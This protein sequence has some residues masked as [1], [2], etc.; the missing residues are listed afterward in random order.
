MIINKIDT[1]WMHIHQVTQNSHCIVRYATMSLWR[2]TLENTNW[3]Q[4]PINF[5]RVNPS[6]LTIWSI[7]FKT[8]RLGFYSSLCIFSLYY[9]YPSSL[10]TPS[11]IVVHQNYSFFIN[12]LFVKLIYSLINWQSID[13]WINSLSNLLSVK[14]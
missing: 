4:F 3:F 1:F 9:E 7:T 12:C 13:Y 2:V 11:S 14:I 6:S 10:P 8:Y 5:I